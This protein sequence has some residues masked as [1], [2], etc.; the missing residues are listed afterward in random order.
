LLRDGSGRKA[1]V[2]PNAHSL[3]RTFIDFVN[4]YGDAEVSVQGHMWTTQA[5]CNDFVE[6]TRL[7]RVP[8][9]GVDPTTVHYNRS[10]FDHLFNNDVNFRVYGE[11]S[12]FAFR[13]LDLWKDK[14]DLKYPYWSNGIRDIDKA[15]RII[16]EWNLHL[17]TGNESLFPPFIYIVLPNDHAQGGKAGVPTVQS[18][19]ADNDAGMG[20]LVEWISSHPDIW[21]KTVIFAIEDDPQSPV[22]DHIDAHRSLCFA[23][24]PWVKRG[25][26]CDTHYSI[27]S[28]YHTIELI[29]GVPHIN[30]NTA[31]APPLVDIFTETPDM[32][33]Y[34]AIPMQFESWNN[35]DSGKFAD[36]AEQWDWSSFDGH[37]GYGDHV[38]RLMNGDKPRPAGAKYIEE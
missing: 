35:P 18:H 36:E 12:N 4:F 28:L 37:K 24:S 32:T 9:S 33:P 19:V 6:K 10:I 34:E 25:H 30:K 3:A 21:K 23:A 27:P 2:T 13:E 29:L 7:D 17:E 1:N 38:W 31:L 22:G 16:H 20:M 14:V 26:L 8:A 5:D 15:N 11:T